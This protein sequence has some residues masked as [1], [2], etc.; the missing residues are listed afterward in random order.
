MSDSKN[1]SV[2]FASDHF[3]KSE[4]KDYFINP[5]C[6]GDDLAIWLSERLEQK[7]IEIK[8]REPGQ[9]DFGWYLN[10]K[11]DSIEY[12]IVILYQEDSDR[13]QCIIEYNSG[14]LGSLFGKRTKR[15]PDAPALIID[16]VLRSHPDT[17]S[18]IQ[19]E[20]IEIPSPHSGDQLQ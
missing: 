15:V 20:N 6:Y 17:I 19:W 13:W 1:I 12:S 8:D 7:G 9:E 16:S 3:N 5:C 14:I 2:S 10:F 18:G 11:C 4:Q